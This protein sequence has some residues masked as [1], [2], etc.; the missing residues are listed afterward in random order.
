MRT[1]TASLAIAAAMIASL[2]AAP[3]AATEPLSLELEPPRMLAAD[4]AE[5]EYLQTLQRL[6]IRRQMLTA[7]QVLAW[8]AAFSII[9]AEVVGMVNR[10]ALLTGSIP[11]KELEPLLVSHRVL[12][13]TAMATYWSA[14]VLAWTMPSPSGRPGD[15][16][17]GKHKTS[18]DA[19]IVLS[20]VHMVAM[21]ML[22][23]TGLLMANAVP[24]AQW[25]P[26]VTMHTVSG[27][28]AAGFT[29]S[30]A[31]VIARM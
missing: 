13:G 1:R 29:L 2:L 22:E 28:V 21:G 4:D 7:H 15:K 31:I 6:Q 20:I 26:L 16:P 14:G 5:G 10:T 17:I 24:A 3:A 18:R 8:T 27:F 23:A 12:A 25:E 11:R 19:H 9:G 30:A